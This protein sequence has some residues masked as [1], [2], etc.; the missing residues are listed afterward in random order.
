M[1]WQTLGRPHYF[2][3]HR[4]HWR[5]TYD[6]RYGPDGWRILQRVGPDLLPA[7][8]AAPFLAAAYAAYL[9]ERPD[10]LAW[11][12]ATAADVYENSRSNLR[13][14]RDYT[15]QE[16][17]VEHVHDVA[18]RNAVAHLGR[19]FRGET[20]LHVGGRE[21]GPLNPGFVPFHRPELIVQPP[22]VHWWEAGSVEC[23]WQS[24]RVLQV[25]RG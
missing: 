16:R 24:G 13:S 18:L 5:R 2:G 19:E 9:A 17:H 20:L 6:Q 1:T 4:H 21:R 23:F 11:L 3:R 7:A 14:G 12:C 8:E 25:R 22:A 10:L 15:V